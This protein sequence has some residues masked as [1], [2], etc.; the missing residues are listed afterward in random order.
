MEQ[1]IQ[2]LDEIHPWVD[3]ATETALID[4]G[5]LDSL[6]ISAVVIALNHEFGIH[7][8][9]EDISREN[10]NSASAIYALVEKYRQ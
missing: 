5:L 8:T 4:D 3:Y 2:I 9:L 1:I 7:I 10:F 6:S